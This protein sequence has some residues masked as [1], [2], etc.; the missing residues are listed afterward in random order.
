M[1]FLQHVLRM[2]GF[3]PKWHDWIHQFVN[4]VSVAIKANDDNGHYFQRD[5]SFLV[6]FNNSLASNSTSISVVF[7]FVLAKQKKFK[8]SIIVLV[9]KLVNTILDIWGFLFITVN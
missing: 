7:V 8:T 1:A 6:F 2:K 3:Q 5:Y 9:V 4:K